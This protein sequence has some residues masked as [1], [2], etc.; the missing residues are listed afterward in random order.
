MQQAQQQQL[1]YGL[2]PEHAAAVRQQQQHQQNMAV[3]AALA[4]LNNP[5]GYPMPYYYNLQR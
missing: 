5:M 3:Q 4:A 2:P 1:P